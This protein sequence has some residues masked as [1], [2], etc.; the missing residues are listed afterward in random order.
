M[1]MTILGDEE[2]MLEEIN[3][4]FQSLQ[5]SERKIEEVYRLVMSVLYLGNITFRY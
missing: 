1:S 4:A 2:A 3:E 5:M